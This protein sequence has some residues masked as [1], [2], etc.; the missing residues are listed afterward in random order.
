MSTTQTLNPV[1]NIAERQKTFFAS[2]KTQNL[3]YRKEQLKKL[4]QAL[5]EQEQMLIDAVKQDFGKPDFE[6]YT[7]EI[8]MVKEEIDLMVSRLRRWAK[9]RRQRGTIINFPSASYIQP[10]PYGS[11]LVIGAWNY[12]LQLCLMPLVGAMA[13]GN[14]AVVKP[15]ELAP[16]SSAALKSLLGGLYDEEYVAVVEGAVEET[17]ELLNQKFDYI[18]FTGS[19]RV[20]KIIMKAAAEH[21]TPVTLELG[22]KSPAI[23]ENDADL[24]LA[25]RRI[26]WGKFMNA[27]QTCVAPDYLL[28]H[29]DVKEELL[30][31]VKDHLQKFYG[32]HT[33]NNPDYARI[34][35][36]NHFD[37]LVRLLESGKSI[38]G[39]KHNRD[40]LYIEPTL[41]DEVSLNSPIMNE[42]I[43]GPILPVIS[44]SSLEDAIT[45]VSRFDKPLA[46]YF[47]SN[48]R[49]KQNEVTNRIPFGG[50]CIN[51]TVTHLASPHLPFGGVGNSGVGN[52]H[53]N[54]SFD[55]FSHF[56]SIL[57]KANW[58]DLP[59]RY[60][61]Y[62]GKLKWIKKLF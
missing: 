49:S 33:E 26:T 25:A 30:Q 43:F 8:V 45:T 60:P 7:T 27:G 40:E 18:F 17:Q 32:D 28:V 20:G 5:I 24:K 31:Q 61:P 47:F 48:N 6:T 9:P 19:T 4:K 1:A 23:V 58:L 15:S 39:G 41:L 56:K 37:R 36:K 52:Y 57:K 14:C 54:Y 51:E 10:E 21:L 44:Y 3:A 53:G 2:G 46:F 55:T 34:I 13:A 59:L 16:N 42:E 38:I 35:N 12:P 29:E 22:G 50:G 11:A 62:D